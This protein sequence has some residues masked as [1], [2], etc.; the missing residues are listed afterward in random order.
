LVCVFVLAKV[1]FIGKTGVGL[2]H[3]LKHRTILVRLMVLL[4]DV[5]DAFLHRFKLHRN[6]VVQIRMQVLRAGAVFS[7]LFDDNRRLEHILLLVI[8]LNQ[9]FYAGWFS[10]SF[11]VNDGEKGL[12]EEVHFFNDL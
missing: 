11:G 7:L 12:L 10:V 6:F 8:K 3:H 5:F 4:H 1:L 2:Q 9:V